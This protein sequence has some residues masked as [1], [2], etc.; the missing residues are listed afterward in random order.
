MAKLFRPFDVRTVQARTESSQEAIVA[1]MYD[2]ALTIVATAP[3]GNRNAPLNEQSYFIGRLVGANLVGLAEAEAA[4]M[5]SAKA[6][7]HA[8]W[9]AKKTIKS[10][11]TAGQAKPWEIAGDVV[12][13]TGA[14]LPGPDVAAAAEEEARKRA[15]KRVDAQKVYGDATAVEGT[16]GQA[17]LEKRAIGAWP[18]SVR[19][20]GSYNGL[21]IPLTDPAGSV[22]SIQKIPLNPDLTRGT[23]L[24]AGPM[25]NAMFVVP[26]KPQ[27]PAVVTDGPEDA[28][29][30]GLATGWRAF[31][32]C[33]KGRFVHVLDHLQPGDRLIAVRDADGT[34]NTE[35]DRLIK[36]A[37][38][39]RID[40]VFADPV[41]PAKDA[42]DML[43]AGGIVPVRLWLGGVAEGVWPTNVSGSEKLA[44]NSPAHN[45]PGNS[46]EK[47]AGKFAGNSPA[48]FSPSAPHNSPA[49]FPRHLL[50]APGAVGML[51]DYITR[52]AR[53]P[54]PELALGTSL[55][56]LGAL[57][58]RRVKGPTGLRTNIMALG[59]ADSGSGKGH[60]RDMAKTLLTEL[61]VPMLMGGDVIRSG[62]GLI[63][64]MRT[65][66]NTLYLLDEIGMFLSSAYD[67]NASAHL[68][69]VITLFTQFFSETGQTWM[70]SD[71]ADRKLNA[72]EPIVQP[73]LSL[74]GISN[75]T[76]LWAALGGG[77]LKDGSIA[78]YLVFH[79]SEMY[80]SPNRAALS[81]DDVPNS[82]LDPLRAILEDIPVPEGRGNLA[83][84][85][86][87][88]DPCPYRVPISGPAKD[89]LDDYEDA[90]VHDRR[91][92][93]GT[94][95][96]SIIARAVEH[97]LK[98]ACICAVADNP[99]APLITLEHAQ[100][101]M[102]LASWS[103]NWLASKAGDHVADSDFG[104]KLNRV[105]EIL[106]HAGRDGLDK[107][108]LTRATSRMLAGT[109]ERDDIIANLQESGQIVVRSIDTTKPKLHHWAAEFAPQQDNGF[110]DVEEVG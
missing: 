105:M 94:D 22:L 33:S 100:Y 71:Y 79:P 19:Y 56:L 49:G 67:K 39:K 93:A 25:D 35:Y 15:K 87:S 109:R 18:D 1:K 9:T 32:A 62:S 3:A 24:T 90:N 2:E 98:I 26:G 17:Y 5:S 54:Q 102:A 30:V 97:A 110:E 65:S 101:G 47:L 58:G 43:R 106:R 72:P 77:A 4:L 95:R 45:S 68:R 80:P 75:P 10:G 73:H 85:V 8:S 16:R 48:G 83:G 61:G 7:G 31:A 91:R 99:R 50:H 86:A 28:M 12:S 20:S 53:F 36:A 27:S 70:G 38:E 82:V 14:R 96:T 74:M 60:G 107:S 6:S 88:A 78:R 51:A 46:P 52:T 69:E 34:D 66:P 104:K 40:L 63:A 41:A 23:K 29:S 42:N 11:L 21:C 55:T 76:S 92:S 64:R 89:A 13:M 84:I 81:G 57:M 103:T 44:G 59:L 37:T 108:D